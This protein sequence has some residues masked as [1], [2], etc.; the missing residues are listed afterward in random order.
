MPGKIWFSCH[1]K[2]FPD[3]VLETVANIGGV[4]CNLNSVAF[5]TFKIHVVAIGCMDSGKQRV[6]TLHSDEGS[7]C[8]RKFITNFY[9]S[10]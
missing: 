4:G 7:R 2:V 9:R 5:L 1:A 8:H 3:N 10:G 6:P